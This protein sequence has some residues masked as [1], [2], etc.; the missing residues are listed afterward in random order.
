MSSDILLPRNPVESENDEASRPGKMPLRCS[1]P[2]DFSPGGASVLSAPITASIVS[3]FRAVEDPRLDRAQTPPPLDLLVIAVCTLLRGGE[4]G[5][6][7][8]DRL[9]V[10]RHRQAG[11]PP[12][13]GLGLRRSL[14]TVT[15]CIQR[16]WG[17]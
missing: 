8:A 15:R 11:D 14:T 9:D 16:Y 10:L 12:R 17:R 5:H 6:A 1:S 3:R 2:Y 13:H 7:L 4:G